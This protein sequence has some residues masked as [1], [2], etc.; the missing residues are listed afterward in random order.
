VGLTVGGI[1]LAALSGEAGVLDVSWAAPTENL[2]GSS[3]TDLAS[4]RVYYGPDPACPGSAVSQ[5]AS[6]T[7]SPAP[8][9]IVSLRLTG[10]TTG[11]FYYV[12]VTAV[13]ANGV[14]S[15]CAIGG[16]VAQG[17][18]SVSPTGT[19]GFG[20]VNIGS[21]A[22]QVFTVQ[23]V[24]GGTV[25]G[26]ASALAPFSVV[27]GSPFTLVG[28]GATQAVTV[29][30]TPTALATV[31]TNVAFTAGGDTVSSLATG[32]GLDVT[33]D[34]TQDLPQSPAQSRAQSPMTVQPT[35]TI[36]S[37][38]SS[39]TYSTGT[40]VITLGGTAFDAVEVRWVMWINE[41]GAN[42]IAVGTTNWTASG[43]VLHL[44]T[45]ELTVIAMNR[46]GYIA[47]ATL[48]VT[49]SVASTFTDDPLLAGSTSVKAIHI[50]ELRD[51][52]N[53]IRM[54]S[55][56]GEFGWTDPVLTPG[57]IP[58]RA[59]H[60]FELRTGLNDVYRSIGWTPPT[61]SDDITAA[62]LVI[63]AIHLNAL[64][65]SVRALQ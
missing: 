64:R 27:S 14:E 48:T 45:N 62:E 46:A 43:I 5:V 31:S 55:G 2:D 49:L 60:L 19:V 56:L 36:T 16:A 51:V 25:S 20:D 65:A 29:R 18:F 61:Y 57:T 35:I 34:V 52:I 28:S 23:N 53:V 44:G 47:T 39:S 17:D 3:L 24:R 40:P 6:P 50:T 63:K 4:Y 37:P 38:T 54:A 58:I 32:S 13:N 9:E 30:F 10:L 8:D 21:F 41:A 7:P 12:S 26:S 15:E 11:T 22:D 33:Q 59:I 1:L 42:G